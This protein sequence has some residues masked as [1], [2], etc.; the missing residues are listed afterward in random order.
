M[1]TRQLCVCFMLLDLPLYEQ[2]CRRLSE[3]SIIFVLYWYNV[4]LF[5]CYFLARKCGG[6][7]GNTKRISACVRPLVTISIHSVNK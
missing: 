4:V 6:I 1:S 5:Y 2:K 7:H 3:R